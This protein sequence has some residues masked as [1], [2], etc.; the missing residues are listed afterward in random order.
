MEFFLYLVNASV[1]N[2]RRGYQPISFL[3]RGGAH[4]GIT[5]GLNLLFSTCNGQWSQEQEKN[6]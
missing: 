1:T 2:L 3:V 4:G 6:I 5:I